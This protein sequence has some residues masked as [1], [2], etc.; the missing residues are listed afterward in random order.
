VKVKVSSCFDN[1]LG[2]ADV[3]KTRSVESARTFSRGSRGLQFKSTQVPHRL[4]VYS[5]IAKACEQVSRGLLDV[6]DQCGNENE[7]EESTQVHQRLSV[8]SDMAKAFEQVSR[9]L[10]D[11]NDQCGDENEPEESTQVPHRLSVLSDMAKAFEQVSRG[12][13]DINDQCG[14]ELDPVSIAEEDFDNLSSAGSSEKEIL[15]ST[16]NANVNR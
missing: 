15:T 7:R 4:S 16:E 3:V 9:G 8:Y 10:L 1:D 2:V 11:I 13:L 14:D 6:N 12:L 5:D